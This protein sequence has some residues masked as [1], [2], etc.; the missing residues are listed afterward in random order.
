MRLKSVI[1]VGSQC[2]LNPGYIKPGRSTHFMPD[3][4]PDTS[5]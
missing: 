5:S 3:A 4:K 2:G 1:T